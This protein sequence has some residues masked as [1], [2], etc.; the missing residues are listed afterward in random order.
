MDNKT[1]G[2]VG[3]GQL[4][5]MLGEAGKKLGFKIIVLDPTEGCPASLIADEHVLGDFKDKDTVINFAEKADIITFEIESANKDALIYLKESGK[6][7]HPSPQTLAI[8]KDKFAQKVFLSENDIPVGEFAIVENKDDIEKQAEIF[9]YPFLL[10]ARFGAYDGRGNFVIKNKEDID[11]AWEKWKDI[12]L[13]AERFVPFTKELAC[14]SARDKGG[15]IVSYFPVETIHKNNICHIVKSPA[16]VSEEIFTKAKNL[17]GRVL[18]NLAG[19]G[20]FAV[21]MFLT[22]D[23]NIFVNEIAPRVH[24]SGHHTI[25]GFNASQF[26]NHIRAIS[27]M[28]LIDPKPMSNAS[29][30]INI[31][32]EREGKAELVGKKEAENEDGVAVHIYGKI[33]TRPERKM[34]HI[35]VLDDDLDQAVERAIDVRKK[36]S[37]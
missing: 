29:A 32:G 18:E 12:P 4:G 31:L 34:G 15:K 23:G 14:V 27:G 3:G 11:L 24:N 17:A 9:G 36:I 6:E 28:P 13:Y 2:I 22:K 30:M 20:V 25:E 35:T 1:I 21:E 16:P 7:V 26:E 37:I 5:K 19:V 10:K 33:D 8:I